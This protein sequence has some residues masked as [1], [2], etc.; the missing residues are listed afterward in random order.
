MTHPKKQQKEDRQKVTKRKDLVSKWDDF[1]VAETLPKS[2]KFKNSQKW[3]PGASR[4]PKGIQNAPK[5][6][7]KTPKKHPEG[8]QKASKSHPEDVQTSQNK[9]PQE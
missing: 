6:H 4:V 8:I 2:L 1:F 3:A 9:I 7:P 5:R